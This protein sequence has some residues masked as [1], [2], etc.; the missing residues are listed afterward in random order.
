MA[1]QNANEVMA[2]RGQIHWRPDVSE[3]MG[4]RDLSMDPRFWVA[5]VE[6]PMCGNPGRIRTIRF[7]LPAGPN[8]WCD[9]HYGMGEGPGDFG[10]YKR[11]KSVSIRPDK[12]ALG[13]RFL[14]QLFAD[15]PDE[16]I[17]RDGWNHYRAWMKA[18]DDSKPKMFVKDH[19]PGP[20]PAAFP[21]SWMP[22]AVLEWQGVAAKP[23]TPD[24]VPLHPS[25]DNA[26]REAE[27][28]E[29]QRIKDEALARDLT[30]H[31]RLDQAKELLAKYEQPAPKAKGK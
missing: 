17:R 2:D 3:E 19:K 20:K 30:A 31:G 27:A 15:D 21:R 16:N 11:L 18:L 12:Y 26:A 28:L 7:D 24:V 4:Y 9:F 14:E 29:R 6:G 13:A 22:K 25:E 8:D 10:K 5:V 23:P 1:L